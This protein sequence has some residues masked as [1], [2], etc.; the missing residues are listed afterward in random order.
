MIEIDN[1]ILAAYNKAKELNGN[2]K[3]YLFKDSYGAYYMVIIRSLS[4]RDRSKIID[5]IYD[6]IYKY[7]DQ[8]DL[9]ILF[10]TNETYKEFID[11][12]KDNLQ[13]II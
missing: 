3:V 13:R 1:V 11:Q 6:E 8:V 5:A 9:T 4:C 10:L 12:N 2:D 7:T